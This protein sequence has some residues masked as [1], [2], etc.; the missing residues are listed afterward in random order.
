VPALNPPNNPPQVQPAG[1][2]AVPLVPQP[3]IPAA[4]PQPNAPG[5]QQNGPQSTP[6]PLY[7]VPNPVNLQAGVDTWKEEQTKRVREESYK[8]GMRKRAREDQEK[9]SSVANKRGEHQKRWQEEF[10]LLVD[11]GVRG[12]DTWFSTMSSILAYHLI[13]S[14]ANTPMLHFVWSGV[15]S[16]VNHGIN[17]ITESFKQR[18][19]VLPG[20]TAPVEMKN[21]KLD[22]VE[23]KKSV[24]YN[25]GTSLTDQE[26]TIF[27]Q[28][29]ALWLDTQDYEA[30]KDPQGNFTGEYVHRNSGVKLDDASFA[31]LLNDQKNG[32]SSFMSKKIERNVT[33]TPTPS[34]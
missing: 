14:K 15:K 27:T 4:Q 13:S 24:K 23:I 34:P 5:Q 29:V 26:S 20:I 32:L 7:T 18:L 1:G 11:Q 12:Y 30:T 10:S 8:E 17:S 9:E 21:G 31:I 2:A 28:G 6:N 33:L 22:L 25:D 16:T 19:Q 3:G